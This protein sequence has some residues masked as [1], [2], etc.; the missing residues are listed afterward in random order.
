MATAAPK[1]PTSE[2]G[3][4][5]YSSRWSPPILDDHEIQD[6]WRWP[7]SVQQTVPAMLNDAHVEGMYR[8]LTLSI[9]AYDWHLLPNGA[10]PEVVQR[11]SA[12]YNLPIG[13]GQE[14]NQARARRRFI[15][16]DHLEDALRGPAYGH[17][18]FEPVYENIQDGNPAVNGGWVAHLRKLAART[19]R[20]I[21][22]IRSAPDGGLAWI[23]VPSAKEATQP[24]P[25][26]I[27]TVEIPVDRLVAYVWDREGGNWLG[28]SMLRSCYRPFKLKDRVIRVG[29]INIERAGGVPY[30]EAPQGASQQQMLD[31]HRLAST[32]RVGETAG[33]ALPFGAQLKFAQAAGGSEAI[34]FVRLQN[35]EMARAWV[36]ML[37]MLG[38]TQTGSRALGETFADRAGLVEE[39]VASWFAQVFNR[40]V[41]EDDVSYNEGP[42][43]PYAPLVAFKAKGDPVDDLA[44]ALDDAQ[45]AGA[46]P[47]DSVAAA[48]VK[49]EQAGRRR[50]VVRAARA[51]TEQTRADGSEIDS[52]PAFDEW[53]DEDFE[54]LAT[55]VSR[56][57]ARRRDAASA[58]RN[59][60]LRSRIVV[61]A[62]RAAAED[63]PLAELRDAH[64]EA[65]AHLQDVFEQARIEQI[66][67][68]HDQIAAAADV[69][70]LAAIAAPVVGAAALAEVLA[71]LVEHGAD[72][73][74]DE[75]DA[76]GVTLPD[77]DTGLAVA[78]AQAAAEA[79]AALIA[80]RLSQSA[81]STA[82]M[83]AGQGMSM[84][85]V[86][87]EVAEHLDSLA[88]SDA[89]YELGGAV[90]R[91]QN[92]GRFAAMGG[93]PDGTV[94]EASDVNDT[95]TCEP[96]RLEDGTQYETLAAARL[97][98]PAGQFLGCLGGA[99]CRCAVVAVYPET[100]G[101]GEEDVAAA[102]GRSRQRK[103]GGGKFKSERQRRFMWAQVPRAARKWAHNRKTRR[104]DWR[105]ARV[106]RA[107][108]R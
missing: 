85:E 51:E 58:S 72:T 29:A 103:Y 52:P 87:V 53:P 12:D 25:I 21:I 54:R 17:Y 91:A 45:T 89:E 57:E 68:L 96:C 14:I 94:F 100:Q 46:L 43:E 84:P 36:Q 6:D 71:T 65:M 98:F 47:A 92:E 42:D 11:V 97:D 56:S 1:A 35:E 63:D 76:Q 49:G 2:L 60:R 108:R 3:A 81:A 67:V 69:A 77:P 64:D 38:Q 62:L 40:H 13:P 48:V 66:N 59:R 55:L 93:A 10:R 20:S 4:E 41:I 8:A 80:Q 88:G 74:L 27:G 23:K 5:Q 105:G 104:S 34:D 39:A 24:G 22:E 95:N 15:F 28:R 7:T 86:A 9:R 106:S 107:R 90:T 26:S 18:F 79:T 101:Q 82:V 19:P 50:R 16:D 44:G 70:A 37:M 99:R 73:A 102:A 30:V 83:L 75:A 61:N 78:Q 33:A 31:L 32:F